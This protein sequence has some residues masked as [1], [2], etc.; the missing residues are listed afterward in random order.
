LSRRS[1]LGGILY[2]VNITKNRKQI[3]KHPS[4]PSPRPLH[5]RDHRTSFQDTLTSSE[6]R[7][8][9]ARE[10]SSVFGARFSCRTFA[11][12]TIKYDLSRPRLAA[13]PLIS[14]APG[15]CSH[16]SV[17]S[18]LLALNQRHGRSLPASAAASCFRSFAPVIQ[19][20]ASKCAKVGDSAVVE[21][22]CASGIVD[23]IADVPLKLH[24]LGTPP[25]WRLDTDH[26]VQAVTPRTS[27]IVLQSVNI[28]TGAARPAAFFST[29]SQQLRA[30]IP[31]RRVTLLVN[32]T[33]F[34]QSYS[35][36]C[37]DNVA[38]NIT[39]I[40]DMGAPFGAPDNCCIM[41]GSDTALHAAARESPL[42]PHCAALIDAISSPAA[43][44]SEDLRRNVILFRA[45]MQRE[46]ER[47]R[48][49]DRDF[50][51]DCTHCLVSLAPGIELD[52]RRFYSELERRGSARVGRGSEWS[53]DDSSFMVVLSHVDADV[54]QHGLQA[55]SSALDV[56][57]SSGSS[58]GLS[59]IY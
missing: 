40:A 7:S 20:I 22:P 37:I 29:L 33:H 26:I 32:D 34:L 58:F 18:K 1:T 46:S 53:V 24:M 25:H 27:L 44:S 31:D 13:P 52:P 41:R 11:A 23:G 12:T 14:Q 16:D 45:W 55:V 43:R 42:Q 3:I 36:P 56:W 15:T 4:V 9:F 38:D 49:N 21:V 48:W 17:A 54:L 5:A 19:S 35:S 2:L 6:V 57:A 28:A 10:V 47:L 50:V 30:H 8:M 39:F 51:G 59:T